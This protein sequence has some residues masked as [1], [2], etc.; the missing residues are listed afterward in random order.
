MDRNFY[1]E[2]LVD[3]KV[4][5]YEA[6]CYRVHMQP[7][8]II[9]IF[10]YMVH[11]NY[12]WQVGLNFKGREVLVDKDYMEEFQELLQFLGIQLL[13]EKQVQMFMKAMAKKGKKGD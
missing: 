7:S 2:E 8:D 1:S 12:A 6:K 4:H 3:V 13:T 5:Q 10:A 9:L 11:H